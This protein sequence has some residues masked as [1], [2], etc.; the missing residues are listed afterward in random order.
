MHRIAAVAQALPRTPH[1]RNIPES[2]TNAQN[3]VEKE[4]KKIIVML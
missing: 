4:E 3:N 1:G 2:L